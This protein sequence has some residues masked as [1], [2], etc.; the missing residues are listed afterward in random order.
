[1]RSTESLPSRIS[2]ESVRRALCSGREGYME[3]DLHR[4]ELVEVKSPSEILATL[5]AEGRC[6]G[7]PFMPE[8][9]QFCG[10]RFQVRARADKVCDTVNYSGSRRLPDGVM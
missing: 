10:R 2:S 6:D 8:M 7:L 1:M 3:V 5:D 9:V 4:G